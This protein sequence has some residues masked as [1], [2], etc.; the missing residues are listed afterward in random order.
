MA[1]KQT[2]AA[3]NKPPSVKKEVQQEK[4]SVK[5]EVRQEKAPGKLAK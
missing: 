5:K 4:P 2:L 1:A 3:G